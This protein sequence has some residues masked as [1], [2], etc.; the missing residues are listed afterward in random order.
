MCSVVRNV[1]CAVCRVFCTGWT[2]HCT[3]CSV[4]CA[5]CSVECAVYSVQ[6]SV[7]SV[8]LAVYIVQCA[9]YSVQ[10]TVC[11]VQCAVYS[12]KRALSTVKHEGDQTSKELEGIILPDKP[13]KAGTSW[14]NWGELQPLYSTTKRY[15]GAQSAIVR[16]ALPYSTWMYWAAS[17][18]K[19]FQ[20][21]PGSSQNSQVLDTS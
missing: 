1:W 5:V 17:V 12:V 21:C 19:R 13:S 15:P 3:V 4:H 11:S 18:P 14:G 8:Q 7:C 20:P 9:V 6:C 10:W 16:S 2:L